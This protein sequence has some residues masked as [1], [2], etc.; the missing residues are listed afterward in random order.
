[1]FS[2]TIKINV[3]MLTNET[4]EPIYEI[5]FHVAQATG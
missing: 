2:Y 3:N 5:I 4:A 1:M